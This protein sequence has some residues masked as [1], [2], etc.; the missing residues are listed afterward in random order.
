MKHADASKTEKVFGFEFKD[1]ESQ[2]ESVV[3][4]YVELL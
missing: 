2:V 3:G 1:F 4:H